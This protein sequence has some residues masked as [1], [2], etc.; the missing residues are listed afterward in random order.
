MP[1]GARVARSTST[2][3]PGDVRVPKYAKPPA[4]SITADAKSTSRG[5]RVR[6]PM[7]AKVA[8]STFT[9][10]PGDVKVPKNAKPPAESTKAEERGSS[11]DG[12]VRPPTRGRSSGGTPMRP[13]AGG[14]C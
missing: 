2:T 12:R 3:T 8:R 10:T 9:T 4:E 14:E 13:S 6:P 5:G 7:R 11:P 1:T